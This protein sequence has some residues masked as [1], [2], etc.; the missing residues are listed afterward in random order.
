MWELISDTGDIFGR[1]FG[2]I[3]DVVSGKE[4]DFNG[5]KRALY[6]EAA[7]VWGTIV[8][9]LGGY[10]VA[11]VYRAVPFIER[12]L[13]PTLMVTS[14]LMIGAIIFIEVIRRFVFS[15]QFPWS[16]TIPGYLFL[17]MTWTGCS[18]NVRLRTH[19][20][21]SEFRTKMP[22]GLQFALLIMD[23]VLWWGICVVVIVTASFVTAN[24]GNNYGL[25]TGTDWFTWWFL[26][27]LPLAFMLLSGRVFQNLIDDLGKYRRGDP[28]IEQAV[29]G[30]Q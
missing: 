10:I 3:I 8:T 26:V 13:E 16:T 4:P 22:R 28:M 25:I 6:G 18:Y 29:L 21:F 17:I 24:S 19:L 12:N 23:A 30:G 1:V 20:S 14:Y 11:R 15:E 5:L 7:W 27:T 2:A 9:L